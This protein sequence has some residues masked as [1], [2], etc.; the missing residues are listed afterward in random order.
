MFAALIWLTVSIPFVNAA[1]EL[2]LKIEKSSDI[3]APISNNEEEAANPFSSTTEEKAPSG[4]TISINEEYLHDNHHS[5]N[6]FSIESQ[7]R[8]C[9]NADTYHAY[10]GELL[11]PPPNAA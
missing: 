7:Y 3:N 8:N 2:Q 1:R 10:H 6:F 4:G 5:E 9:E 11:V